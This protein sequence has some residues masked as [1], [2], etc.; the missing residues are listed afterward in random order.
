MNVVALCGSL[1]AGSLNRK[2]LVAAA[3]LL[4]S[5]VL[6]KLYGELKQL[7]P[8]DEDDDV[9][10]ATPAA[11]GR[12]RAALVGADALLIATPEYNASLPGQLKNAI[13]WASR[14]FPD[15]SVKNLPVAVIGAST[16]AFG[17]VWAQAELRKV[18]ATAGA[19]VI[20]AELA[21][22]YADRLF[23]DH[24]T[25]T[26]TSLREELSG[27]VTALHEA[28]RAGRPRHRTRS[29]ERQAVAA[30]IGRGRDSE[31]SSDAGACPSPQTA[32]CGGAPA[33]PGGSRRP[34]TAERVGP[35]PRAVVDHAL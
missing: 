18:L 7:P 15:N 35:V 23:D 31:R 17:G 5:G 32:R 30:A 28:A 4:P 21:I 14:P 3:D 25:L 12:L 34:G 26:E 24:G 9:A 8:Y 29:G 19:R 6:F 27:V 11:V 33:V 20:K 2:L 13:D 16:S 22:P 10:S 1:R